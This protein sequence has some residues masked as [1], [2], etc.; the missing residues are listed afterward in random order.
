M[1]KKRLNGVYSNN[2]KS[3]NYQTHSPELS[4]RPTYQHDK[5]DNNSYH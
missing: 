1:L 3:L 2:A 4:V 5:C